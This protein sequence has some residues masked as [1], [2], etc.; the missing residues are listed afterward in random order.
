VS[1][2]EQSLLGHEHAKPLDVEHRQVEGISDHQLQGPLEVGLVGRD[3]LEPRQRLP[4]RV[5]QDHEQAVL[6]GIEVVVERRRSDAHVRRNVRPLGV[7]V[8]VATESRDRSGEN[9][10]SLGPFGGGLLVP[11][12]MS[13]ILSRTHV[14]R[15]YHADASL[16]HR[17]VR[18]E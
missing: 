17:V 12:T 15:H 18:A 13:V 9:L 16:D 2:S 1:T 6:L 11:R 10:V 14:N 4:D 8:A 5:V 3:P 7:L